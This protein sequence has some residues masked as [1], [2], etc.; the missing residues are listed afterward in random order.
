MNGWGLQGQRGRKKARQR[1]RAEG[2]A[3]RGGGS[4]KKGGGRGGGGR[5]EDHG[6]HRKIGQGGG[7]RGRTGD[8]REM[9]MR[10]E[11]VC[12][13]REREESWG[14]RREKL[15]RAREILQRKSCEQKRCK[16]SKPQEKGRSGKVKSMLSPLISVA[17]LPLLR[18]S[19]LFSTLNQT[20]E[21]ARPFLP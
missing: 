1:G 12:W 17:F 13:R 7:E 8:H 2:R 15:N 19:D 11:K 3:S 10:R 21:Q 18:P 20:S 4:V 14:E 6:G 5:R 9:G 16:N